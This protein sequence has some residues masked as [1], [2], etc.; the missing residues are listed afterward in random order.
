MDYEIVLLRER[1]ELVPEAAEWF[2]HTFG[3]PREEYLKSMEEM[4][5]GRD[6]VP[7][8]YVAVDG[9]AIIAQRAV[10]VSDDDTD[11]H[12]L[13]CDGP[14]RAIRAVRLGVLLHGAGGRRAREDVHSQDGRDIMEVRKCTLEDLDRLALW[15]MQAEVDMREAD[16]EIDAQGCLVM[17]GFIDM[18]VHL[19]DPGQEHKETVE[20]GAKAAAPG[21]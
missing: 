8:W 13:P 16:R 2:G 11:R 18:H 17:P 21:P 10:A 6:S 15:S 3:I 9:G 19:R 14:Y 7:Q 1:P 20:T 5:E 12:P 4:L